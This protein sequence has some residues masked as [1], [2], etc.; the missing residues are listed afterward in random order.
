MSLIAKQ[1]R[2]LRLCI[3]N[4]LS[5]FVA[6]FFFFSP[7]IKAAAREASRLLCPLQEVSS[8][9]LPFLT[10]DHKY[11]KVHPSHVKLRLNGD[12]LLE[13]DRWCFVLNPEKLQVCWGITARFTEESFHVLAVERFYVGKLEIGEMQAGKTEV[14]Q[15]DEVKHWEVEFKE[16]LRV[17]DAHEV[18]A[19]ERKWNLR[20][21][22][23]L[24]AVLTKPPEVTY[25][26]GQRV[27]HR[28][29]PSR[30]TA[31]LQYNLIA[32]INATGNASFIDIV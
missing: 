14:V 28:L 29:L 19:Q 10:A 20:A 4:M 16:L 9:N 25:R 17:E 22:H 24:T 11:V 7:H 13:V 27:H 26:C 8:F 23:T 12:A 5:S 30:Q 15:E 2:P 31:E 1:A 3:H 18:K 32:Q 21:V 6:L